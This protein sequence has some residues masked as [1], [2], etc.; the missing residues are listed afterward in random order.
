MSASLRMLWRTRDELSHTQ[1]RLSHVPFFLPLTI[2]LI[3]LDQ[4]NTYFSP[5]VSFLGA[6]ASLVAYAAYVIATL[7]VLL[8]FL[9]RPPIMRTLT[10]VAIFGF[11]A[12]VALPAGDIRTTAMLVFQFAIGGCAAYATYV[13]VFVLNNA[14]RLLS[15]FLVTANYGTFI[16][17]Q[18]TGVSNVF[19]TTIVPGILILA[20]TFCVFTLKPEIYP[21]TSAKASVTPPKGVYLSLLCPFAFFTINVF[22]EELIKHV[23]TGSSAMR[24]VGAVVAVFLAIV[25]QF[26]LRRS[27]WY[28]LNLFL[29]FTLIGVALLALPLQADFHTLGKFLFGIG[30]GFGYIMTF[31]IIGI[32]KKYRNDRFFKTITVA[33]MGELL[34]ATVLTTLINALW[35]GALP[36]VTVVFAFAFLFSFTM[37]SPVF[38]RH[39]FD[40]DWIGDFNKPDM[41]YEGDRS[42]PVPE[43]DLPGLS[44]REKEVLAYLLRGLTV[45]QIAGRLGV[46]ESTAKG[47]CKTLY[48][49][50]GV[51]SRV[52]LFARFGATKA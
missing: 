18:Q 43:D 45:R 15:I 40:S 22:G 2:I 17:L 9:K 24:G 35:P 12:W 16:F 25:V 10:M 11:L 29:L 37:L 36:T 50:L 41:A 1:I 38:Q 52:E 19:L 46:A 39:I 26:V 30:D 32:I 13:H 44:P 5:G 34:F 47:Y 21:D 49:K 27:V 23:Q 6:D 51:H 8:F 48:P 31:Y 7:T 42:A 20:L 4:R 14:E 33:T 28:M 3:L